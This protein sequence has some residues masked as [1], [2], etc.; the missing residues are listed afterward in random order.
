MAPAI[1][2]E[3]PT[4][5][6]RR[7]VE[8]V[9]GICRRRSTWS[10]WGRCIARRR[11]RRGA[12]PMYGTGWMAPPGKYGDHNMNNGYYGPPPPQQLQPYG[13]G[14]PPAYGQQQYPQPTGTTGTNFHPNDGYYGDPSQQQQQQ[15]GGGG[16]Q[17]PPTAYQ[18]NPGPYSPPP[19]PP[20]GK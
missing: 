10:D 1:V 20:P 14:G 6:L 19:G 11:R 4:T 12:Q 7:Y 3:P 18:P 13:G 17:A 8:C 9:D 15:Y 5:L 2:V 16:V